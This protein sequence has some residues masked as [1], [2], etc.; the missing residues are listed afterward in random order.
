MRHRKNIKTEQKHSV[1]NS[2][3]LGASQA[4][5]QAPEALL[6]IRIQA[7]LF[8]LA[9]LLSGFSF[10]CLFMVWFLKSF[11]NF[12]KFQAFRLIIYVLL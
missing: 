1:R 10:L 12:V 7:T 5:L 9:R 2:G 8:G 6:L 4:I 11:H 3:I